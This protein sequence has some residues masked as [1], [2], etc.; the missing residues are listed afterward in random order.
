MLIGI[1]VANVNVKVLSEYKIP[2]F[3]LE[4]KQ[5]KEQA[6]EQAKKQASEPR[7]GGI[8][9]LK[10][11]THPNIKEIFSILEKLQKSFPQPNSA[12]SVL[13]I[14]DNRL[15]CLYTFAY[16]YFSLSDK[17]NLYIPWT[18]ISVLKNRQKGLKKKERKSQEIKDT[19]TAIDSQIKKIEDEDE[20]KKEPLCERIEK[21]KD[22]IDVGDIN[23]IIKIKEDKGDK[24]DEEGISVEGITK[25]IA[26]FS[27]KNVNWVKKVFDNVFEYGTI[28][29]GER[30]YTGYYIR[31]PTSEAPYKFGGAKPCEFSDYLMAPIKYMEEKRGH[32]RRHA[33][34]LA[35]K[36]KRLSSELKYDNKSPLDLSDEGKRKLFRLKILK[37]Q[38]Y[39]KFSNL[40]NS[41]AEY[42][43][44]SFWLILYITRPDYVAYE[45]LNFK[46][47]GQRGFLALIVQ[48]MFDNINS[49]LNKAQEWMNY[50][51]PG[52]SFEKITVSATNTS[53]IA[54]RNNILRG[55]PG[56]LSEVHRDISADYCFVPHVV[57]K[58]KEE[59]KDKG[60]E[61][62]LF[63]VEFEI[64]V[65]HIEAAKNIGFKVILEI[66][67]HNLIKGL[68][69]RRSLVIFYEGWGEG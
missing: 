3:I 49:F 65:S 23:K 54:F 53:K 9:E 64:I 60:K 16:S 28:N 4:L 17:N 51:E 29:D 62:L 63:E 8:S 25:L 55:Y 6:K 21:N 31:V 13:G 56:A 7:V 32:L 35:R 2:K 41:I 58:G 26:W 61:D 68:E 69:M 50:I 24:G 38:Y 67:A 40:R 43:L 30:D 15:N 66:W 34:G 37:N 52:Y 1:G 42:L 18:E 22:N 20:K 10:E 11:R 12:N 33:I 46:Q 14:D 27:G 39:N 19:I 44:R 5:L 59:D 48:G 47:G 45:K 57:C 36:I